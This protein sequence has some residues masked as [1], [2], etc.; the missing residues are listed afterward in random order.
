[1]PTSRIATVHKNGSSL[2]VVV[3]SVM[4]KSLNIQRGDQV[5]IFIDAK[6]NLVMRKMS[7]EAYKAMRK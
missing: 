2:A 4:C 5:V 6:H 3:P 1:M 7:L